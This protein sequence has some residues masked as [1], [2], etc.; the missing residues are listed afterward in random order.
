[1]NVS[2]RQ[3]RYGIVLGG[4]CWA[5]MDHS[6]D[7]RACGV[8]DEAVKIENRGLTNVIEMP[9]RR[10]IDVAGSMESAFATG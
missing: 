1:M 4:S 2:H 10:S 3:A 8:S 9:A 6:I 5:T 7:E